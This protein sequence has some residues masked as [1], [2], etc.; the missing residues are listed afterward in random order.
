MHLVRVFPDTVRTPIQLNTEGPQKIDGKLLITHRFKLDH[1]CDAYKAIMHTANTEALKPSSR[2][3]GNLLQPHL[4]FYADTDSPRDE[5]DYV[6]I[7]W[8]PREDCS[9]DRKIQAA[10]VT[11]PESE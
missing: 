5:G 2:H 8:S 3:C 6:I 1:I 11:F 4:A 10:V 7:G 9:R